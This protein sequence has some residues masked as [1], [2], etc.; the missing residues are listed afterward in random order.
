MPL[1]VSLEKLGNVGN[2]GIIRIGV[3]EKRAD[4]QKNLTDSQR[5][6]P[7]VFQN[8]KANTSVGIDVAMINAC[9][10]VDLRWLKWIVSWEV[11][12]QEEDATR[13]RRVIRSHDS[14]LPMKHV[15]T[16]GTSGAV[17]WGVFAEV[18]KLLVDSLEGHCC[19]S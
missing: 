10:E 16:Y 19:V 4:T 3:G 2:Q 6:T 17:C 14:C 11:N 13:I 7:L 15:I 18:D 12:I 1:L 8:I 9:R 5:W